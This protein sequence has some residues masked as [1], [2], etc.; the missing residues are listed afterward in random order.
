MIGY[1]IRSHLDN[2]HQVKPGAPLLTQ[3]WLSCQKQVM[4]LI[5]PD[6][7]QRPF[8][9]TISTLTGS[10]ARRGLN[11][12]SITTLRQLG[13]LAIHG[14]GGRKPRAHYE[15]VFSVDR[16]DPRGVFV[17]KGNQGGLALKKH[18]ERL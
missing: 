12:L 14:Y 13:K 6:K 15:H 4:R 10:G 11:I 17:S 7:S 3:Q 16:Y 18:Q 2:G 9:A 8:S 5:G 1:K